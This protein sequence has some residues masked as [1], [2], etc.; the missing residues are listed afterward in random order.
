M[1]MCVSD[2]LCY[3]WAEDFLTTIEKAAEGTD[4]EWLGFRGDLGRHNDRI[5]YHS[6][7]LNE[8]L[9][10]MAFDEFLRVHVPPARDTIVCSLIKYGPCYGRDRRSTSV[11]QLE[12]VW[13]P[14]KF[15][16][17]GFVETRPEFRFTFQL[18]VRPKDVARAKLLDEQLLEELKYG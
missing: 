18:I 6:F 11:G 10:D 1:G 14:D 4:F 8:D 12:T 5:L 17:Q 3:D 13:D 16:I 9:E 2:F 7:V 15:P